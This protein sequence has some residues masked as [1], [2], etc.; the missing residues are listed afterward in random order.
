MNIWYLTTYIRR[1]YWNFLLFMNFVCSVTYVQGTRYAHVMCSVLRC[2]IAVAF[3]Y[4]EM[5]TVK[6]TTYYF[7]ESRVH[8]AATST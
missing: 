8:V 2:C 7:Y 3:G 1:D 5:N 4:M 6:Y